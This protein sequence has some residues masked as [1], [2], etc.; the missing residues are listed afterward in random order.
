[1]N[2]GRTGVTSR[3]EEIEVKLPCADLAQARAKIS[4]AG[5][6]MLAALHFESNDLFDDERGS[7]ASAGCAL[8]L[9]RTEKEALLTFKGPARFESGVKVRREHE[10]EVSD[11][12]QTEEILA[13]LGLARRFRYEKRREEWELEGCVIALD[14]TPLGSF[15]EVE[16]EPP[17][18]RRVVALLGLDFASAIPYTYAKL[19]A[20]RRKNDPALPT[21]MVFQDRKA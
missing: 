12:S 15:V 18:I 14:E 9:R 2:S 20:E 10:T 21:D 7:L 8:R 6:R 4:G 5:G 17:A 13:G 11:A 1:M 19:Y 3:R 16:G